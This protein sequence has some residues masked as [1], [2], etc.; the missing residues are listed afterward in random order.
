M[1][2][3]QKNKLKAVLLA[4]ALFALPFTAGAQDA[5]VTLPSSKLTRQA[6]LGQI[7]AQTDYKVIYSTSYFKVDEVVDFADTRLE[8]RDLLDKL[9]NE[10]TLTYT[11]EGKNVVIHNDTKKEEII[12]TRTIIGTVKDAGSAEPLEGVR[13]ELLDIKGKSAKTIASGGFRIEGV[14]SG[15]YIAKLTTAG[16]STVRYSEIRVPKESDA[17]VNIAISFDQPLTDGVYDT[18]DPTKSTA[19]FVPYTEDN[20]IRVLPEETR[21]YSLSPERGR[22][23]PKAGIKTNLL[24][25]ATTTL[26]ASVEIGL[27]PR[28]TLDAAAAYNPFQLQKGGINL[29]WFVQPE[30]R[31]WFC[32]RFERH[33]IGLHGIYGR[34]NVGEVTFLTR[35]FE[36]HRYRG[37][38]AGGGI[39]YGYHLPMGKHWGWEFS[40]G[41]GV[42]YYEY[43]KFRCFGCDEFEG[44]R[45]K[46]YFGPTKA[47]IS[48][49]YMIK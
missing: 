17:Y 26:N 45:S 46:I 36:N 8:L 34:F 49:I 31:Y 3:E 20:S 41:A 16:G 44:R 33:F 10:S 2:N 40:V 35:T 13:V 28:W 4:I 12:V 29:F 32:D 38:G 37:W 42:I 5:Y 7:S 19:Y 9:V 47:A 27:A 43:D 48:L 21:S 23:L 6:A 15:K 11:L 39:S 1:R 24:Y 14:P 18:A 30:I 22:Y 25:L